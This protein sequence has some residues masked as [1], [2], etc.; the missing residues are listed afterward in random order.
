MNFRSQL[1]AWNGGEAYGAAKKF[2]KTIGVDPNLVTQWASAKRTIPP[3]ETN[4]QKIARGFGISVDDAR[5]LFGHPMVSKAD[6]HLS[7]V[8]Q[9]IMHRLAALEEE[10]ANLKGRSFPRGGGSKRH[11]GA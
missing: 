6:R 4:L 5:S 2:A 11:V 9:E 8:L 3:R 1:I 10:M 7:E